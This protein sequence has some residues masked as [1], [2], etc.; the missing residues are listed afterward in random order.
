MAHSASGGIIRFGVRSSEGACS[1]VFGL[2]ANPKASDVYLAA[3][4]VSGDFKLS[5]LSSGKW[6]I[7]FTA[8]PVEGQSSATE[9]RPPVEAAEERIVDRWSRPSEMESGL[10]R[11]FAVLVASAAVTLPPADS[12]LG[13]ADVSWYPKPQTKRLV[14]FQV[15]LAAPHH[16]IRGWPGQRASATTLIGSLSLAN[17]ETV[18]VVA[19]E[20][21]NLQPHRVGRLSPIER[22][23]KQE[24]LVRLFG[25]GPHDPIRGLTYGTTRD[26]LRCLYEAVGSTGP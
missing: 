4:S 10:T 7:G 24:A 13:L 18:W 2:W 20:S 12:E 3:H 19:H 6:Q 9:T 11:A 25:P 1:S 5:L 21:G 23:T 22:G 15:F 16:T 8:A 26:G 14:E 17:R